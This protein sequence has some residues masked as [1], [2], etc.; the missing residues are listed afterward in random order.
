MSDTYYEFGTAADRWDRAQM[1]F[2]AKEY[3]SAARILEGLVEEVPEQVS[4]RLLLARTYYHSA[5]LGRA[6]TELRAVLERDPVEHYARLMLGRT[7]ER[8][9]RSAEAAGHLRMAAAFSGDFDFAPD[10]PATQGSSGT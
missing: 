2:E 8:Q 7:L 9:G 1:F 3:M 10:G 6:E 5:R 4:P